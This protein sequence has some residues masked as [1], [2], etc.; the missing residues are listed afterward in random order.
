MSPVTYELAFYIPE[1]GILH[2]PR[3]ENLKSD[4]ALTGWT[5]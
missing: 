1:D 5:L 4:I 3:S 2:S